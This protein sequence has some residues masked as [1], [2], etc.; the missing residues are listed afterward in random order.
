MISRGE[1]AEMPVVLSGYGGGKGSP[2]SRRVLSGNF[3]GVRPEDRRNTEERILE[4]KNVLASNVPRALNDI[5]LSTDRGRNLELI[6]HANKDKIKRRNKMYGGKIGDFPR[7]EFNEESMGFMDKSEFSMTLD[8]F[9][10]FV[11]SNY[12]EE[13]TMANEMA[14]AFYEYEDSL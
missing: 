3:E 4:N 2:E 12:L 7:E 9:F 1:D 10:I 11:K 6:R 14:K 13:C 8:E 5:R